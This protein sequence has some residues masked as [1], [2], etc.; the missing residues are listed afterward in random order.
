MVV[1]FRRHTLLPLD[2]R[3]YAL[4]PSIPHLTRSA[5]HRRLQRHGIS[6]LPD[7]EGK[8][9]TS[10]APTSPTDLGPMATHWLDPGGLELRTQA[11]DAA[12]PHALRIH[13]QELDLRDGSIHPRPDP[14]DAGTDQ[15]SFA[16]GSAGRQV[17]RRWVVSGGRCRP[18]LP[19]R[20]RD[21]GP[22]TRG[23]WSRPLLFFQILRGSGGETPSARAGW[24][25]A[26]GETRGSRR[27]ALDSTAVPK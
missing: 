17:P 21:T 6:R 8:P 1:A 19:V 16:E 25:K 18:D 5:L 23:Q 26:R 7:V 3:L 9:T 13:L 24:P 22:S 15:R 4:Q 11:R 10:C 14:P 20:A 12:R 27:K 2:D